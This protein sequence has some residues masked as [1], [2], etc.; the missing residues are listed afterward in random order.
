MAKMWIQVFS[1][2]TSW[3][4]STINYNKKHTRHFHA[5]RISAYINSIIPLAMHEKTHNIFMS[6]EFSHSLAILPLTIH[7]KTHDIFMPCEFPHRLIAP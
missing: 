1:H 4:L 6:R 7:K 3:L 2:K 5:V